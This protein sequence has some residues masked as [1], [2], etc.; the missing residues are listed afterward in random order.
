M[1]F[2]K[3]F[4]NI[5][6]KRKRQLKTFLVAKQRAEQTCNI[7]DWIDYKLSPTDSTVYS[8]SCIG[9]SQVLTGPNQANV[10]KILC[11]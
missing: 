4:T 1:L 10:S 9:L 5:F 3:T 2:I 7:T 11:F 8:S 6:A